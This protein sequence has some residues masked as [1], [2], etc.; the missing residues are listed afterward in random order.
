MKKIALILAL[1]ASTSVFAGGVCT[2]NSNG[3]ITPPTATAVNNGGTDCATEPSNSYTLTVYKVGLCT[4]AVTAPTSSVAPSFGSC[5]TILDNTAGTEI[6]VVKGTETTLP[7]TITT[8]ANASYTHIYAIMGLT[9]KI[10]GVVKFDSAI[11]AMAF[12]GDSENGSGKV[13]WTEDTTVKYS[14]IWQLTTP[15]VKCGDSA[16]ATVGVVAQIGDSWGSKSKDSGQGAFEASLQG[17]IEGITGAQYLVDD[18]LKLATGF[19]SAKKMLVTQA[20]ESTVTVNTTGIN[21][22]FKT[23]VG[24]NIG[25]RAKDNVVGVN[26]IEPGVFF[27]K[28]TLK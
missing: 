23:S 11:K 10:S 1:S 15:V 3:E 18:N 20:Q 13:C 4:T 26:T 22:G 21:L 24:M 2:L 27:M 16:P 5:V 28:V 14:D 25:Y 12:S 17:E 9:T 7:G 19:A 6:K 8:P